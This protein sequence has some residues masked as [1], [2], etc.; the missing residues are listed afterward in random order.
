MFGG[1]GVIILFQETAFQHSAEVYNIAQ[2][3]LVRPAYAVSVTGNA[4]D[5]MVAAQLHQGLSYRRPADIVFFHQG[6]FGK[7]FIKI[8]F[9]VDN[10]G[11]YC[12]VYL[13]HNCIRLFLFHR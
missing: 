6:F 2:L 3:L 8:K 4:D 13:V 10:I 7:V 12:I 11:K 5:K 9:I 1:N